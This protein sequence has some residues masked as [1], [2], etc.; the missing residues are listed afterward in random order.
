MLDKCLGPEHEFS[1]PSGWSQGSHYI[2]P[3]HVEGPRARYQVELI[4]RSVDDVAKFLTYVEGF[5]KLF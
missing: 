2:N 4:S 5:D 3:P 1:L